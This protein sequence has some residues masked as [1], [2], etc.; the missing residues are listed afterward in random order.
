MAITKEER[1]NAY[2]ENYPVKKFEI[3]FAQPIH[4]VELYISY[5]SLN[6]ELLGTNIVEF[7]NEDEAKEA[8]IMLKLS[9]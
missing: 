6:G 8:I 2:Y 4:R 5:Y 3:H 7:D 1:L 9:T